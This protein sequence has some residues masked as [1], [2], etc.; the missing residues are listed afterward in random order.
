MTPT[1]KSRAWVWSTLAIGLNYGESSHWATAPCSQTQ[2]ATQ[3]WAQVYSGRCLGRGRSEWAS[4]EQQAGGAQDRWSLPCPFVGPPYLLWD[5]HKI[6]PH[7]TQLLCY[8]GRYLLICP[9]A[10]YLMGEDCAREM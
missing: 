9:E 10:L 1:P 5:E 2:A 7:Q 3:E 6:I 4:G 8:R